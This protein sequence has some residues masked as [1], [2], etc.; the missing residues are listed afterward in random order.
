[1]G[2]WQVVGLF[3]VKHAA[4]ICSAGFCRRGLY[5]GVLCPGI[6]L[7]WVVDGRRGALLCKVRYAAAAAAAWSLNPLHPRLRLRQRF[8][9][10]FHFLNLL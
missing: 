7:I 9:P 3:L 5:A 10:Q 6:G 4:E 2:P 8:K 1:M